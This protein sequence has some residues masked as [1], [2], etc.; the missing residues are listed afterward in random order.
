MI[1][2]YKPKGELDFPEWSARLR[3]LYWYVRVESRDKA[4]RRRY[5]RYIQ[6]EKLRLAEQGLDQELIKA[7]CRY[8][9]NLSPSAGYRV[10]QMM[11]EE[12]HQLSIQF[13]L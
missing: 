5:Y 6:K 9:T 3:S 10:S 12:V 11:A 7:M 1:Y 13:V 4:K 8:L 2:G